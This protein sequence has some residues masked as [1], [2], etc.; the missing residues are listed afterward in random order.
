MPLQ[1]GKVDLEKDWPDLFAAEWAAWTNP[2]QA[3]WQ[4]MFPVNHNSVDAEAI[5][6]RE[7]SARQLAGSK[8]DSHDCWVKVVDSDSNQILGGALWKFF[9]GNPYRAPFPE[10]DAIWQPD[11]QLRV[12][13]NQMYTQLRAWRPKIMA[14]AHA[15]T[16]WSPLDGCSL[17]D[18]PCKGLTSYSH[19]LPIVTKV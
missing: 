9:E 6:I 2:P 5:A 10:F 8:A 16:D 19:I 11:D 12:L 18:L 14:T 1:I 7:G 3:V 13:C 4:L 15:C 17:H